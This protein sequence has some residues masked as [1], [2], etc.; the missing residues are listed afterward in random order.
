MPYTERR[1]F[2]AQLKV[3]TKG[4][5]ALDEAKE[6]ASAIEKRFGRADPSDLA[7]QRKRIGVDQSGDI[8][9]IRDV[10]RLADRAIG[11]NSLSRW[12]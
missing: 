11:P 7:Q 6:T 8:E 2:V 3:T 1:H 4:R 9:R 12:S 5:K 10:V